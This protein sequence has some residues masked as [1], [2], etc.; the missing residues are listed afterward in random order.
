LL[1]LLLVSILWKR[2]QMHFSNKLKTDFTFNNLS[3]L[4][5]CDT[6]AFT[7]QADQDP[8]YLSEMGM[9]TASDPKRSLYI[10]VREKICFDELIIAEKNLSDS[11]IVALLESWDAL[12]RQHHIL[13][14][15]TEKPIDHR[16]RYRFLSEAFFDMHLPVHPIEMQ[17]CFV[18]D[19][20]ESSSC[21]YLSYQTVNGIIQSLLNHEYVESIKQLNK[22]VRLNAYDNLSE[23]EFYYIVNQHKNQS[24][25]IINRNISVL[26]NKIIGNR[27]I[28]RGTHET[29]FCFDDHCTITKGNW[30]LEMVAEDGA[31][32]VVDIQ[33]EGVKFEIKA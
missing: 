17:F 21:E 18:Y 19:F 4:S 26:S 15:F 2:I 27:L 33:V 3:Q 32:Q 23:P 31:W 28:Y 1:D 7:I 25:H 9:N 12:L 11:E 22:R 29:D 6:Q 16:R 20:A 8:S 13:V 30:Q 10:S 5:N 24:N 14:L